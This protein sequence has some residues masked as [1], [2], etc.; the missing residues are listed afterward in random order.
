MAGQSSSVA[1]RISMPSRYGR[2]CPPHRVHPRTIVR[3]IERADDTEAV[4]LVERHVRWIAGFQG[5][6]HRRRVDRGE[7]V[8][9]QAQAVP[10]TAMLR[11][12]SQQAEVEVR[13]VARM[14]LLEQLERAKHPLR[15]GPE[16]FVEELLDRLLLLGGQLALARWDP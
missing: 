14:L 9:E 12:G 8:G 5:R 11:V 6:R 15:V 16:Q 10:A 2:S 1:S 7:V 13:L 3:Q 4:S